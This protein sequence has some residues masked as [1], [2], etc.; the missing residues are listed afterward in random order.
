M[1][2]ADIKQSR[3]IMLLENNFLRLSGGAPQLDRTVL[4]ARRYFL[5]VR[6]IGCGPNRPVMLLERQQFLAGIGVP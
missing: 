6:R 4:T 2:E 3:D 1:R 5:S